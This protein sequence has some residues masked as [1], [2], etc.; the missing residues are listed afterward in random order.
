MN[1]FWKIGTVKESMATYRVDKRER[2]K[3]IISRNFEVERKM[4]FGRNLYIYIGEIACF[5][6]FDRFRMS[7]ISDRMIGMRTKVR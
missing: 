1:E 4:V 6:P 5:N 2:E 3:R 7:L